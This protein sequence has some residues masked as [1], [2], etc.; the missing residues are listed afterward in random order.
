MISDLG[1][2]SLHCHVNYERVI[3]RPLGEAIHAKKRKQFLLCHFISIQ[4]LNSKIKHE[5]HYVLL[6]KDYISRFLELL[7]ATDPNHYVVAEIPY[8]TVRT[9]E[10][11]MVNQ[12]V[13]EDSGHS[14]QLAAVNK[15]HCHYYLFFLI[16]YHRP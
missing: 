12:D 5:F 16:E 7:P 13:V 3:P 6:L 10:V 2:A 9:E 11:R 8:Q 1:F 15:K 14:T 4:S